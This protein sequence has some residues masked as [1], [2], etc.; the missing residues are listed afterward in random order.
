[1]LKKMLAQIQAER[2]KSFIGELLLGTKHTQIT[3]LKTP[4]GF[5]DR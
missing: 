2:C 1:M 5:E 4:K 3:D